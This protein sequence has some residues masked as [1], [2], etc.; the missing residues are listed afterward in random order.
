MT[1]AT[2]PLFTLALSAALLAPLAAM[3]DQAYF[4]IEPDTAPSTL[5]RAQVR[6][7]LAAHDRHAIGA[8]GWQTIDGYS[9]YVGH[10]G[11]GKTRAEVLRELAEFKRNPVGP[12]GWQTVDGDSMYVGHAQPA[13]TRLATSAV[14]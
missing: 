13:D 9:V 3:A 2:R 8:D 12:D 4:G 11:T 6:A 1:T 10:K 14:R 7:E 5:T